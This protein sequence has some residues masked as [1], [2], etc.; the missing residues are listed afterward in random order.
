MKIDNLKAILCI[1]G[2]NRLTNIDMKKQL[3]ALLMSGLLCSGSV[4][5]NAQALTEKTGIRFYEHHSSDMT[6]QPFG[7]GANGS[8]SGYDFVN[9]AYYNSF[10][11]SPMGAYTNG[12]EANLDMVEHNGVFGGG[13]SQYLGFTSGVSTIWNGE[14]KGNGTTKWVKATPAFSYSQAADVKTLSDAYAAGTASVAVAAVM[15][16]DVYIGR[17]RGGNQYV[18]IKCTAAEIPKGSQG[19]VTN[20][21]FDFDYKT[22]GQSTGLSELNNFSFHVFPNPVADM[23]SITLAGQVKLASVNVFDSKGAAVP[24]AVNKTDIDVRNLQNGLY[25]IQLTTADGAVSTRRFIKQ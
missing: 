13:T 19:S 12:E 4:T 8:K 24:V 1:S 25:F 15:V 16:D 14:I 23:I 7:N 6:G 9:Q 20:S 21:Y 11:E 5:L 22:G 17:I 2:I 3:H 18:V 10:K